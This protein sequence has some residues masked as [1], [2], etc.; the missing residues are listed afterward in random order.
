MTMRKMLVST[1]VVA[2]LLCC[3]PKAETAPMATIA[4]SPLGGRLSGGAGETRALMYTITN[5][6]TDG[7]WLLATSL[8]VNE[9]FG[10]E[11]PGSW[12]VT[13]DYPT[14]AKPGDL[15][16]GGVLDFEFDVVSPVKTIGSGTLDFAFD[17]YSSD[18][19]T[20][21][22][23]GDALEVSTGFRAKKIPEPFTLALVLIGGGAAVLRR[24]RR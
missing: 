8:I 17:A 19:S 9:V 13:F 16:S 22:Q 7:E 23:P 18:P 15:V 1:G 6:S 11:L 20:G 2:A 3:A 5:T 14:I 12:T 4:L 10:L 21:G 24:R